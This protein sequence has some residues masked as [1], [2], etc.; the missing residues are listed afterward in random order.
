MSLTVQPTD[1]RFGT[2]VDIMVSRFT[3]AVEQSDLWRALWNDDLTL[4][5]S[6]SIVQTIAAQVWVAHCEAAGVDINREAN[7]GR[8]P[9]DFKFSA[10]WHSRALI[11]IKML[12]NRRVIDGALRQLPQYLISERIAH[13]FYVCVGFTDAELAPSR[14]EQVRTACVAA[15]TDSG[16]TIVPRFVDARPKTSAS[17]LRTA[18]AA[19]SQSRIG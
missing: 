4:P 12:S 9:V 15:S 11:E 16:L 8:G 18:T 17:K 1:D 14:T 10:G 2:W 7:I 5:R 6:E 13:G 3:H 19:R